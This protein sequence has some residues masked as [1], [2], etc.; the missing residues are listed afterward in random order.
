MASQALLCLGVNHRTAPLAVR[1]RLTFSRVEVPAAVKA[2]RRLRGVH[3]AVLLS[4]CNRVECYVVCRDGSHMRGA[5]VKFF[6]KLRN[7]QP[8]AF[9]RALYEYSGLDAVRHLIEVAAGLDSQVVGEAQVLSQVREAHEMALRVPATS[10]LLNGVFNRALAA[11]KRVRH[12]TEIGRLPA[13]VSSVA[14]ELA[15][16]IFGGLADRPVLLLGTGETSVLVA[17]NLM[18]GGAPRLL[19]AGERRLDRA[20]ALA[21]KYRGEAV[22][23]G[24]AQTR[25]AEVDIVI[26]AT[27]AAEYVIRREDVAQALHIR[28]SRPMFLI[29]LAVP[30]NID[31]AV[32]ELANAYLY[33]LDDLQAVA[34]ENLKRRERWVAPAREI[35]AETVAQAA[36]WMES[37][38]VVP[39]IVSLQRYGEVCRQEVWGRA[40]RAVRDLPPDTRAEVEYLTQALVAKLLHRPVSELKRLTAGNGAAS[41]TD[42]LR[43]LFKLG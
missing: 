8:A 10:A 15:E 33:N 27:A 1:E 6:K 26:V 28:K 16:K 14:V 29:D 22:R 23:L 18:E 17:E 11:A 13:S 41:Y 12:E 2:L 24:E 39:T 4:T 9:E 5:L 32:A 21:A 40:S 3:E 35:V 34:D 43:K 42:L 30:R 36:A 7:I 25:L 31:P 19:V 38:Q 20:Q 37:L